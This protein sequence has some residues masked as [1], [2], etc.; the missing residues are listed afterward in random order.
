MNHIELRKSFLNYFESQGH[1]VVESSPLIPF[2]DPTLMFTNAGMNQFKEVL[3]GNETRSYKRAASVQKCLRVSG[4]HNDFEVVGY[5]GYHHT[6]FEMLGN[7]S[8]GDYYKKEEIQFAWEYLTKV[9]KFPE[10]KLYVS[11]YK[12]DD[13]SFEIWNKHV[14][15]PAEKIFRLGDIE[16][17]DEENF[18]S[19]GETGPC[20]FCSEIYYDIGENYKDR[21]IELWNLVFMEFYRDEEGN[22]TPLKFK[23]VDTGMGLERLYAI[24]NG[25]ISN[26]ETALFSKIIEKIESLSSVSFN[27]NRIPFQ[28]IADHIRALC[29]ALSDGGIFSNEGRGYILRKILR[30]ASRYFKKL[31]VNEPSL[32]K[33]VDSVVETMGGFYV[34]LNEKKEFV[35]NLIKMEEERFFNTLESGI[36]VFNEILDKKVFEN[37]IT[38][39]DVFKL[40]DTYGFPIEIIKEMAKEKGLEIDEKRFNELMEEQRLRG[41][42]S[43]KGEKEV[44]DE[45]K[46]L[47]LLNSFPET[48]IECYEKTESIGKIIGIIKDYKLQ[49]KLNTDEFGGIILDA[50]PFYAES[51]GQVADRGEILNPDFKF[52]VNDVQ[53]YGNRYI[54]HWGVVEYGELRLNLKVESKVDK[55]LRMATARNHTATHLLQA[56][57]RKVLGSYIVQA[58]SYVGPDKL[59][60]DFRHFKSLTEEEIEKVEE[61]VNQ[62]IMENLKIDKFIEEKEKAIKMGA[63]AVF[64]E[65]YGEK[66]RVIKCGDFSLELCGGTHLN[67]TGEIGFFTIIS[68]SAIASGIRRIEALTGMSAF[69]Y[70]FNL[71]KNMI[72]LSKI[73]KVDSNSILDRVK[74]LIEENIK[75]EKKIK[76]LKFSNKEDIIPELLKNKIVKNNSSIIIHKFENEEIKYLNSIADRLKNE[77]KSGLIF[78]INL[79]DNK[80]NFLLALTDDLVNNGLDAV[81]IINSLVKSIGCK[82]GGRKDRAQAGGKININI[83]DFL[84]S[85]KEKLMEIV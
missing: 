11:V 53:K 70:F 39:D 33:L 61:L 73:L 48:I 21:Y 12:D 36:K 29:F 26:Y 28:V 2:D 34:E 42:S 72:E 69:K 58:G 22:F 60:F 81:N 1:K 24:L 15:I 18:W 8:F 27:E 62:K 78:L 55:T 83:N 9:L 32:Y 57:L 66:V 19:M 74:K 5:D 46:I 67:W 10:K 59:R 6:F 75:Y 16:K 68:E 79:T 38:G 65:K 54:V 37:R 35:K 50:T 17:G 3:L 51:G 14:K 25:K 85:A 82:G 77:I 20:G 71:R 56:A 40:Y 43:F 84:N 52:I 64:D 44:I 23:S 4:K 49:D 41:K 63:M 31:N 76:E 47:K 7:W 45:E 30:R 13:E 80:V